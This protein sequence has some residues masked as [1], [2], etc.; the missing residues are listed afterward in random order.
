MSKD[1][2]TNTAT[3]ELYRTVFSPEV[4]HGLTIYTPLEIVGMQNMDNTIRQLILDTN[5]K[6]SSLYPNIT[7]HQ[8]IILCP[9]NLYVENFKK[10]A[11][12]CGYDPE[13]FLQWAEGNIDEIPEVGRVL[14]LRMNAH[15]ESH[16]DKLRFLSHELAHRWVAAVSPVFNGIRGQML[17]CDMEGLVECDARI[18]LNLQSRHDMQFSTEFISHVT[19]DQLGLPKEI[20]ELKQNH[21]SFIQK[22]VSLNPGYVG[23][24]LWFL[25]QA[26]YHGGEEGN[27]QD[28]Y[29][30][31]RQLLLDIAQKSANGDEY[32]QM[33][34]EE[35]GFNHEQKAHDRE[36]LLNAKKQFLNYYKFK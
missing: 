34:R 15:F 1:T 7:V 16:G 17:Y 9:E 11:K 22:T 32:K 4:L 35:T 20:E 10:K 6:L 29:M 3:Q 31:G 28:R 13:P 19:T 33:L 5:D 36:F 23:C 18:G 26:L 2:L 14:C 24:F 21:S 30:R 25:G 8:N 12:S 27:L